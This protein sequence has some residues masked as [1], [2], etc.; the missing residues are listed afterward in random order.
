MRASVRG[1]VAGIG[2]RAAP[3]RISPIGRVKIDS[4]L[5]QRGPRLGAAN[6]LGLYRTGGATS[7]NVTLLRYA[8]DRCWPAGPVAAPLL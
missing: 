3:V 1:R 5:C 8:C 7:T 4:R 6:S 2:Q